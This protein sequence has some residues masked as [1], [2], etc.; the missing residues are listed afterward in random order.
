MRDAACAAAFAADSHATLRKQVA[1]LRAHLAEGAA[2]PPGTV[3]NLDRKPR[4]KIGFVFPG[5]GAQ[6]VG[7]GCE[8]ALYIDELR[9]AVER[10]GNV[11]ADTFERPLAKL[12]W[13]E[14]AFS[15][16]AARDAVAPI[17]ERDVELQRRERQ[18]GQRIDQ[19][20]NGATV[21]PSKS[22]RAVVFRGVL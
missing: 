19:N 16:A 11:L 9:D 7:M 22:L 8:A 3:C 6:S 21:S 18:P 1:G 12:M 5:Q 20:K 14:A 13:P 2:L 4:Q 10:A 15:D 17:R